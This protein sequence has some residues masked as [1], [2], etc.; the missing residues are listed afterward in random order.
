MRRPEEFWNLFWTLSSMTQLHI[1]SMPSA[2]RWRLWMWCMLSRDKDERCMGLAVNLLIWCDW[3]PLDFFEY[4]CIIRTFSTDKKK[5]Y[6]Q[7]F[8]EYAEN[9][10][11][12]SWKS[13]KYLLPLCN[14]CWLI[15]FLKKRTWPTLF[16]LQSTSEVMRHFGMDSKIFLLKEFNAILS[17]AEK[18]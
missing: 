2:R 8:Y 10:V 12:V 5:K 14:P 7:N 13:I 18:E 11:N 9:Q 6:I 16:F 15:K 3:S 4:C 17:I 1:R